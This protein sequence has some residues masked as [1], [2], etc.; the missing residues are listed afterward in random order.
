MIVI[1]DSF[2]SLIAYRA[3]WIPCDKTVHCVLESSDLIGHLENDQ[4]YLPLPA[5]WFARKIY[6]VHVA[7]LAILGPFLAVDTEMV[8][9]LI[10]TVSRVAVVRHWLS[11]DRHD[12]ADP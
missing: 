6:S 2:S 9:A 4:W 1:R 5:S 10:V 12:L 7:F 8:Y 3:S 11:V